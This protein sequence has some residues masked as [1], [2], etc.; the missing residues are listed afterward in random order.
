M[1]KLT[2]SQL[3]NLVQC[4]YRVELN[5]YGDP[6]EKLPHSEFFTKLIEDGIAHE[7]DVISEIAFKEVPA[8]GT[9]E[10]RADITAGLMK[11]RT[12][13][14][15]QG[16]LLKDEL[17]GIP[18]L[19]EYVSD[20]Y[21][22]VE[23]KSGLR[24]KD[25][26]AMQICFYSYLLGQITGNG[27]KK[28][29]IINANKEFLD[30]FVSGWWEKF[31][32]RFEYQ[33]KIVNAEA[34][35]DLAIGS[36]CNNCPWR[37][38]CES[39]ARAQDDLTLISGLSRANKEKLINIGI[40]TQRDASK[41]DPIIS[42]DIKGL[43]PA[44]LEKFRA[45]AQVNIENKMRVITEP[46]FREAPVEIFIDLEGDP[47]MTVD[48]LIGMFVRDN[49]KEEYVSF[50]AK[51]PE[52]EKSMWFEFLDFMSGI[53]KDYILYHYAD[54]EK[55]HFRMLYERHG[56]DENL[57]GEIIYSLEDLIKVIRHS[58]YLPLM[59]YSLKYVARHLGFEWDAGDEAS[60]ANSILWYQQYL[61]DIEKNKAIMEKIIKYNE[62]DCRAT[63]VVKDWLK[64]LQKG[65]LFSKL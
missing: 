28:G 13:W 55:T 45:Q 10:E 57:Y 30:V 64:T 6:N 2:A 33:K 40:K 62:D 56:G 34:H 8:E 58:V 47:L 36:A 4:P 51:T 15:Y 37:K 29:R 18:D 43:G 35:D 22:P 63:A 31:E 14:I 11:E 26:Y 17:V 20:H 39:K 5:I 24:V 44:S 38:F 7:K 60:G 65:D 61:E 1:P 54:Y 42:K 12:P 9:L 49:G 32:K 19:L 41:M 48:Y 52:E 46:Q 27:P 50:V 23:I 3:Y 25:E 21:E 16:V 59:K 53:K